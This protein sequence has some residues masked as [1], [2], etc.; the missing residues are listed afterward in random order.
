MSDE[1]T[2]VI[3]GAGLAGGRAAET[4]RSEGFTGTVI[5][6]GAES[7]PPYNRPPLSKGLLLGQEERDSV[8]LHD[9]AWYADQDIDLRLGAEA[10]SI[11]PAAQT[12]RFADGGS[13]HYDALLLATGSDVRVLD[14]PGADLDG[15]RYL[16]R[17]DEAE[18]I[19]AALRDGA[20]IVIVGAGWIGLEVA[21]A[22]EQ[23]GA[24]VTVIESDTLPLRRVLGDELAAVYAALHRSHGV[25]LR[26]GSGV[27]EFRGDGAVSSV[28]LTDGTE[29]AAD[30]VI[31]GVGITPSV[32]LAE[33]AGIACDNGILVDSAFRTSDPH[34]FAVG[35]VANIDHAVLGTR[36]RVEHWAN[37]LDGGPA[38]AKAM[39]GQEVRWETLPFFF[40]DQWDFSMEY[41]GYVGRDGY[42]E[43]VFRG[44][45]ATHE[46]VAFWLR[47]GKVL[48]GMNANVWDVNEHIQAL[49]ASGAPISSQRLAD[50]SVELAELAGSA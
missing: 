18:R 33:A 27:Q 32:G 50:E 38:A 16:R 1:R 46:F 21:S 37:A 17:L 12:V 14:V 39:L 28:L 42:D 4:L 34:V 5:L 24:S 13:V 11:D 10:E 26:F 19:G 49:V 15:V 40:S 22:A 31:V 25:D 20:R 7:E 43:V 48:A 6:A 35:D 30:A 47:D 41:A 3:I 23:K 8:F 45:P 44:D 36:V 9:A 29:L 2:F